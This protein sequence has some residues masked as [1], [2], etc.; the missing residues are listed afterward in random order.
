MVAA[1]QIAIE[2]IQRDVYTQSHLSFLVRLCAL[3]SDVNILSFLSSKPTWP[4]TLLDWFRQF[5]HA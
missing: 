2:N 1:E 3:V 5:S 4:S